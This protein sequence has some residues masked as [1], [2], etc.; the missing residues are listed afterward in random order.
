[1]RG[2]SQL[3]N[4]KADSGLDAPARR[5]ACIP[6][7]IK[8]DVEE[9]RVNVQRIIERIMRGTRVNSAR[10]PSRPVTFVFFNFSRN[11]IAVISAS[12]RKNKKNKKK[13]LAAALRLQTYASSTVHYASLSTTLPPGPSPRSTATSP[14]PPFSSCPLSSPRPS[15][16]P[17]RTTP[18]LPL[19]V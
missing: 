11:E 10:P 7:D 3:P 5:Y 6:A 1:M 4:C 8:R 14:P 12:K 2:D 13:K 17:S 16:F 15:A 9:A 18:P 19:Y